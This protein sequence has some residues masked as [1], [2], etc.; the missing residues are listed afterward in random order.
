M[1]FNRPLEKS[2]GYI[3]EK[4][5]RPKVILQATSLYIKVS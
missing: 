5:A 4:G 3:K 1:F 2:A